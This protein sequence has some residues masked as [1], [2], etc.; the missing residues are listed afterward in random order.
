MNFVLLQEVAAGNFPCDECSKVCKS[1]G[2]LKLLLALLA[3]KISDEKFCKLIRDVC[4]SM[5]QETVH[6]DKI[7]KLKDYTKILRE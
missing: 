4:T 2:G 6:C 1:A 7:R 5:L 3:T